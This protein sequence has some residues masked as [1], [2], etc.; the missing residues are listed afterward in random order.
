MP[1]IA[2]IASKFALG[3]P[4]LRNVRSGSFASVLQCPGHVG[5]AANFGNAG[6]ALGIIGDDSDR[7]AGFALR[8]RSRRAQD[9]EAVDLLDDRHPRPAVEIVQDDQARHVAGDLRVDAVDG[10]ELLPDAADAEA[11]GM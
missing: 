11:E 1:R 4:E 3:C 7:P 2:T 6:S 10:L 9:A 5:S 8:R